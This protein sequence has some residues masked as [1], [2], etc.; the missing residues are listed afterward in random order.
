[1]TVKT[2]APDKVVVELPLTGAGS[3]G[4]VEVKVRGHKSNIRQITQWRFDIAYDW[5]HTELE[6]L[7]VAGIFTLMFRADIGHYRDHAGVPPLEPVRWAVA[8]RSSEGTL[9][10]AGTKIDSNGCENTWSGAATFEAG[11]FGAPDYSVIS[12]M[13]IDTDNQ[14]GALGLALGMAGPPPFNWHVQCPG[15]PPGNTPFMVSI[16]MLEGFQ[17]F[18][19]PEPSIPPI[20]LPFFNLAFAADYSVPAHH[21]IDLTFSPLKIDIAWS[22]VTPT[23]PPDPNAAVRPPRF[24]RSRK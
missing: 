1:V 24:T 20:Q 23:A 19:T 17:P 10:G 18:S 21:F 11:G 12:R 22:A 7:S 14:T 3:S 4:D 9:T 16:G 6:P 8:K 5:L 15:S 2:W 13:K